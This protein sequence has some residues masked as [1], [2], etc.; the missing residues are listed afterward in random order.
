MDRN[1]YFQ[2]IIKP[3]GTYIKLYPADGAG[4]PIRFE[5]VMAYLLRQ[6][7]SGYQ[8]AELNKAVKEQKEVEVKLLNESILPVQEEMNLVMSQDKMEA[9]AR[10]YPPSNNASVM[11]KAEL[12]RGITYQGVKYG[13]LEEVVDKFIE[14]REYCKDYVI[15]KGTPVQ[16][17]SDAEITYHFNLKPNARPKLNEDGSV[18]FHKLENINSVTEGMVLATLKLEVQGTAGRDVCGAEIRPKAVT[19]KRLTA[20]KNTY[21]IENDTQ[22]VSAVNGHVILD[23]NGKV[24]VSNIYEIKGDVDTSTGDINYD[25]DVKISG[26][27]LTGFAV[28]ATGDIEVEGVVEAAKITAGG[29]III[30]RGVQGMNKGVLQAGGNVLCRFIESAIVTSGGNIE[31]DAIMHSDVSA[32]GEIHVAGKKGLIVGGTVRAGK[33]IESMTIGSSMGSSTTLAV[34]DDPQLQDRIKKLEEESKR[35]TAEENKLR[36]VLEAMKQKKEKGQLTPDRFEMLQKAAVSY[37]EVK[38]RM[39]AVDT[40]LSACYEEMAETEG[41]QII[42]RNIVYSGVKLMV[43]GEF[44]ITNSEYHFCKFVKDWHEIKRVSL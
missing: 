18:D 20:G 32:K 16:E 15:A 6:R 33:I 39:E 23:D 44:T 26:N 19:A 9:T 36:Q 11:E 7:I 24:V 10:F 17:G 34:G 25:G 3:T 8:M 21:L 14:R 13:L 2:L 41:A 43:G 35:L 38:N 31:V 4:E 37:S 12:L 27:V 22:L 30:K 5:E 1:G 29:K 40:E 42:V 28:A